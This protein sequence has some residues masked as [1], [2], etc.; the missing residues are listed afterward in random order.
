M[1]TYT[2]TDTCTF[3][4]CIIKSILRNKK[5]LKGTTIRYLLQ[6]FMVSDGTGVDKRHSTNR[7]E[8]YIPVL[9]NRVKGHID[10][11]LKLKCRGHV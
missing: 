8:E 1:V 9:R 6:S 4:R 3:L 5:F 10:R 2:V 11:T 7:T